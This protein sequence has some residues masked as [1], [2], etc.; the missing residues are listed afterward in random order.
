MKN[1]LIVLMTIGLLTAVAQTAKASSRT[2][3]G[4]KRNSTIRVANNSA[5]IVAVIMDNVTPPTGNSNAFLNAGGQILYPGQ[6]FNFKVSAGMHTVVAAPITATTPVITIGN[7][8]SVPASVAK[9]G[10]RTASITN[11]DSQNVIINPL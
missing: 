1:L 7:Q 8:A 5:L 3:G 6:I 10:K 2:S 9:G 11:T 4:A